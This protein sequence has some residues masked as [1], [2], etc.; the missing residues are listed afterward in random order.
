LWIVGLLLTGAVGGYFC[1][2]PITRL[3]WWIVTSPFLAPTFWGGAMTALALRPLWSPEMALFPPILPVV[4]VPVPSV[5]SGVPAVERERRNLGP[6]LILCKSTPAPP[7]LNSGV[8][9]SS[10]TS[11]S[12]WNPVAMRRLTRPSAPARL[13]TSKC[14]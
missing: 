6:G 9:C 3:L 7:L 10:A 14:R 12:E 8:P 1:A 11:Q 5:A 2:V 4:L 13:N